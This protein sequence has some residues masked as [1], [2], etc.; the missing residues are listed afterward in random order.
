[1]K[2]V[3]VIGGGI[4]GLVSSILLARKGITCTVIEKKNYPIH[5]VCGE[6]ISNEALPFLKR[7]DLYPGEAS[8]PQLS[9]FQLSS[10]DGK[11]RILPLE[12]GGFGVSRFFFDHFLFLKAQEHGVRFLL[13][14]T[15]ENVAFS[16]QTF[17]IS[18]TRGELE[19]TVVLGA[20]GKRS[21]LDSHLSRPFMKTRSP[22]V[23]VKHHLK[24][25]HDPEVIALHN[26]SGGYCGVSQVENGVVNFCYL[27]HRE[28]LR[29]H[30]SIG[31]LERL[32]LRKNPLLKRI[33]DEANFLFDR[34]QV[35]NEISFEKKS[36]V[37]N[38]ILMVGDSAGLITPLCGNGMAMAIHAA[39]IAT[40]SVE[41]FLSSNSYT[42]EDLER[43]YVKE[44]SE[45]F[46][47]RLFV[48]R[49]LQRLFGSATGSAIAIQLA[50]H[51]RPL[52]SQL[53]RNTHGTPFQ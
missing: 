6:Y 37:E 19:S 27:V 45:T 16:G 38:H 4:A 52:A 33:Y 21:N 46:S 30:K 28:K 8:L 15:A 9:R 3:I 31:D 41:R 14:T 22:Y 48:G 49:Q 26:F 20:F 18:T 17:R 7:H 53:I 39:K 51:V 1:M 5:R 23:G 50:L 29:E 44:W 2:N 40:E 25:A 35:I 24:V 13:E 32:V 10:V 34:P 42:R 43:D 47:R 11:S 36:A 12:L